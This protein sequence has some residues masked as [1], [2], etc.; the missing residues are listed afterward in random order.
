MNAHDAEQLARKLLAGDCTVEDFIAQFGRQMTADLGMAQVD[1]DRHRRCG[2]PE[3]VF[4]EGKSTEAIEQILR[5]LLNDGVEP[6][7]TRISAENAQ[8]LA[9]AFPHA[10]R[11][12]TI[13]PKASGW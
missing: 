1:L 8:K 12:R 6:L 3:V 9:A 2:F 7:A 13:G 4:G 5:A 11:R 10:R